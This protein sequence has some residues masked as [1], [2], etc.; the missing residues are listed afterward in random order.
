MR[1]LRPL[2]RREFEAYAYGYRERVTDTALPHIRDTFLKRCRVCSPMRPFARRQPDSTVSNYTTHMPT[3]WLHFCP[4]ETRG[5]DGYG[6]DRAGRVK[7]PLEVYR[8]VRNAVGDDFVVGCRFLA[9]EI[10]ERGSV[11]DDA[12]F[13]GVEF[14]RAGDGFSFFVTWRKVRGRQAA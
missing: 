3:P 5:G 1:W 6:G 7:L 2:S 14:A 13:F 10:I 11:A 4:R 9:D 8:A 12:A